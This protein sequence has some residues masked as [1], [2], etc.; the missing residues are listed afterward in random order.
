MNTL[1]V[2]GK[3]VY[4]GEELGALKQSLPIVWL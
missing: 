4:S 3:P 2:D 1:K